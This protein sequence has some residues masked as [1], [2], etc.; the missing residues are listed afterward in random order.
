MSGILTIKPLKAQ[1]TRDVNFIHRMDPYVM[2]TLGT[3]KRRT[4][5]CHDGAKKPVWT[6]VIVLNKTFENVLIA[7]VY[8]VENI[9]F[10]KDSWIGTAEINLNNLSTGY[11]QG[12]QWFDIWYD[13]SN[14]GKI[15]ID[16]TFVPIPQKSS[17]QQQSLIV[18]QNI[19][20]IPNEM[21]Y[22]QQGMPIGPVG[23]IYSHQEMLSNANNNAAKPNIPL[24]NQMDFNQNSYNYSNGTDTLAN[25]L[26]TGMK[27]L[28]NPTQGW[29]DARSASLSGHLQ[30][31][32][33][34]PDENI[35]LIENH[36][37]TNYA[38]DIELSQRLYKQEAKSTYPSFV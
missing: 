22:Q 36:V 5:V 27:P 3:Q 29:N 10:L 37:E 24:N 15:L 35:V 4:T 14:A 16:L 12:Q 17:N 18:P 13:Q 2:F 11:F 30:P 32:N 34:N 26:S 33:F 9:P 31:I 21:G 28:Q 6:D 8:N 1:L 20:N 7:Q 19:Q 25:K 38:P 23:V